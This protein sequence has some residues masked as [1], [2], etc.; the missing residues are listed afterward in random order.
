MCDIAEVVGR[1]NREEGRE[2]GLAEGLE[3]GLAEGREEG[4]LESAYTVFKE[5]S[6][7]DLALR[8]AKISKEEFLEYC[9]R[10]KNSNL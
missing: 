8:V 4:R 1:F 10:M 3:K 2:E 5:T 9:E 7:L 6:N